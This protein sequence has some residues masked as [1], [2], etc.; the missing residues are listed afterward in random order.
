MLHILLNPRI[1][2]EENLLS[3]SGKDK[4]LKIDTFKPMKKGKLKNSRQQHQ[5]IFYDS[6]NLFP[7]NSNQNRSRRTPLKDCAATEPLVFLL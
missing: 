3:V 7:G 5:H 6:E 1:K 4:E 2:R